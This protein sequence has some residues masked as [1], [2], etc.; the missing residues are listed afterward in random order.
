M[1]E[2]NILFEQFSGCY[3]S[4]CFCKSL[5]S[6]YRWTL[7]F[8]FTLSLYVTFWFHF[9]VVC[10]S[11]VSPYRCML[12]FCFNVSL[13]AILWFYPAGTATCNKPTRGIWVL[14]P[15]RIQ[16]ENRL[17]AQARFSVHI[18][19][20]PRVN[21]T[22]NTCKWT[23]CIYVLMPPIIHVNEPCVSTC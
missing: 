10:Y 16:V 20:F 14:V 18:M 23:M 8:D 22:Y 3:A 1:L 11:L 4:K 5:V 17:N 19:F 13:Y 12:L 7:F 6:I 15:L 21:A 2:Q 9:I